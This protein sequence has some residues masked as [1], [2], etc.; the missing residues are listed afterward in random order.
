MRWAPR[1]YHTASMV[2]MR[3][4]RAMEPAFVRAAAATAAISSAARMSRSAVSTALARV[5]VRR[6]TALSTRNTIGEMAHEDATTDAA[7]PP[8]S[9]YE[10]DLCLAC[11]GAGFCV[12]CGG[13]GR[14]I[15]RGL[16]A[17]YDCPR[18]DGSGA[19]VECGGSG[20]VEADDD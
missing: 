1:N 7:D 2:L 20:C 4:R 9:K 13:D 11:S 18:C 12:R 16:A 6:A 5:N 3:A 14:F 19:C 17:I 15:P 8:R 10:P